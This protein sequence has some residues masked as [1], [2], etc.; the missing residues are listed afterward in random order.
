MDPGA[1]LRGNHAYLRRERKS[2]GRRCGGH[3]SLGRMT[4]QG[5]GQRGRTHGC[6]E[7]CEGRVFSFA[8][9]EIL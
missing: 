5:V 2:R 9:F 7:G 4:G 8:V 1:A 6:S 3:T